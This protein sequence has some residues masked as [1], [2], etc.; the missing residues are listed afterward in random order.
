MSD[1]LDRYNKRV[2]RNGKNIGESYNKNT[3]TFI[4]STFANAPTFRKVGVISTEFPEITEMDARVIE[5]ERLGT[6]RE[7]LFRPNQN[8]NV[9]T[10][11]TFDDEIWV[12]FG[13]YG[14]GVSSKV[15]VSKCNRTLKWKDN[16][17]QIKEYYCVA[18]ATDLGS[19][20]KQS[21]DEI[22]WNKYDVRLPLGQLFIFVEANE[23]TESIQLNNR[24]IFG[25]KVF[26]ITGVDDVTSVDRNGYG[27]IQFTAKVTTIQ[28]GDDFENRIALNKN[29]EEINNQSQQ[30]LIPEVKD[31]DVSGGR[32]W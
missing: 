2:G 8:L 12:I 27:I 7:V 18:S 29:Y 23:D 5:V 16:N 30:T 22:E 10:Y 14:T 1:F 4:E 3:I 26:E 24:F 19:K 28:N 17:D 6:L 13:K 20:A 31:D 11:L 21:K 9:G 32:I 25:R 15:L